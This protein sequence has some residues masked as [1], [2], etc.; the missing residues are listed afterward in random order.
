MAEDKDGPMVW[1]KEFSDNIAI[2]AQAIKN[3]E[4]LMPAAIVFTRMM[5]IE[6]L[7]SSDQKFTVRK[8][9]IYLMEREIIGAW[10]LKNSNSMVGEG[11]AIALM[12]IAPFAPA[13]GEILPD[14]VE[15]LKIA[16]KVNNDSAQALWSSF[17]KVVSR[18]TGGA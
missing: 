7:D 1:L 2:A 9:L 8:E 3:V 10:V 15:A 5:L 6:Q 18:G 17:A 14:L 4:V 13:L 16:W 12:G 11:A